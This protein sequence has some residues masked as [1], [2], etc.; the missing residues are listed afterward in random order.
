MSEPEA[1]LPPRV[2]RF[3][4]NLLDILRF[5]LRRMALERVQR[6][7]IEE[8]GR[9]K[10]LSRA[11]VRIAEDMLGKGCVSLLARAGGWRRERHL[12]Y[13]HVVEG[14]L[15]ERSPPG[16]L[17]L[18]FSRH[19]L[20]FLIWITAE[21]LNDKKLRWWSPA[22]RELTVGDWLFLYYAYGALR[23][24]AA[25]P[26]NSR[27][28]AFA[29]H[30][31]CRLAYPED[32][33]GLGEAA[34]DLDFAPWTNDLGAFILEALQRE[35]AERWLKVERNKASVVQWQ[36]MQ[37]LARSQAQALDPLFKAVETAGRL[38]L[39]R[40]LL[41]ALQHL[42][43]PEATAD[44]WLE[45]LRERGPTMAERTKTARDALMLLRRLQTM[46]R[47]ATEARGVAFFEENY[48]AS[49]LWKT[50]WERW[51]GDVL[52]ARAE[53]ILRQVEPL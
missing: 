43:P 18:T 41:E 40:F 35:L 39:T 47:W 48:A 21:D 51:Q 13:G 22:G 45:G 34:P 42:L 28:F 26:G 20:D 16:A 27:P 6:R 15:W 33:Q 11:A 38:D 49:Q 7:I 4:A 30:P 32:F 5:F 50:D 10:C 25:I 31:L 24:S 52:H 17:G 9:P 37:A 3:E 44:R 29:G 19:T 36:A 8:C 23:H 12:R 2:S 14:R 1:A 46:R 53:A